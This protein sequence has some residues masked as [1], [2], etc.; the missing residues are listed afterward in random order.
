MSKIKILLFT[1]VTLIVF[2]QCK[3]M[4]EPSLDK[5]DSRGKTISALMN[6]EVYMKEVMDSMQMKHGGN[7]SAMAMGNGDMKMDVN[8]MDRMM[9]K[10][11][12]DPEMCKMMMDKTMAM[13]DADSTMC[14]MM[15]ASMTPHANVMK[16]MHAMCDMKGMKM[17]KKK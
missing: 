17:D 1:V 12:T 8:M 7:M 16:E 4:T 6:N 11:K 13:C 9:E 10:C 2:T 5:A 15:M 14:K 3:D